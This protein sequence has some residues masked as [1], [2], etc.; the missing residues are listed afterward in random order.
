MDLAVNLHPVVVVFFVTAL[1]GLRILK[2]ERFN[3]K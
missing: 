3:K 1:I 2:L